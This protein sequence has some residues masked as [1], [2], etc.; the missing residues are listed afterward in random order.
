MPRFRG[1]VAP[2]VVAKLF[3]LPADGLVAGRPITLLEALG[4]ARDRSEQAEAAR[5]YWQLS[6][7]LGHYRVAHDAAE[8]LRRLEPRVE[9][10]PVFRAA[11]AKSAESLRSAELAAGR[12]QQPAG[13]DRKV[14]LQP[15]AP[16]PCGFA[17]HRA[18]PHEFRRGLRRSERPPFDAA[19]PSHPAAPPQG[20]RCP[21]HRRPGE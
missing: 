9:D 7:A 11:R 15:A 6:A 14:A 20:D 13:R 21:R 3:A 19:D 16:P 5:A 8:R 1:A 2:E 18:L 4:S 10:V 17:A 12:A